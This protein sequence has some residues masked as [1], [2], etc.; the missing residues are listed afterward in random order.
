[1]CEYCN[2]VRDQARVLLALAFVGQSHATVLQTI[3]YIHA[4][5][6]RNAVETNQEVEFADLWVKLMKLEFEYINSIWPQEPQ[7]DPDFDFREHI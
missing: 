5:L 4:A 3:A 2:A 6:R 7:F 1:M